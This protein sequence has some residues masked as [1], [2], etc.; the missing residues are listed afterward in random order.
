M[1]EDFRDLIKDHSYV[2]C[3]SPRYALIQ[4]KTGLNLIN[5]EMFSEEL[6]YQV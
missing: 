4:Y 2:G 5:V 3:V 1:F 6:F